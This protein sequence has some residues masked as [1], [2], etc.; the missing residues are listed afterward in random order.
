MTKEEEL[1]D[2]ARKAFWFRGHRDEDYCYEYEDGQLLILGDAFGTVTSVSYKEG[3]GFKTVFR[4][5]QG[6][7]DSSLADSTIAYLRRVLVL[8]ELAD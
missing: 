4:F 5:M 2:L 7:Q 1:L 8:E 6:I 3:H